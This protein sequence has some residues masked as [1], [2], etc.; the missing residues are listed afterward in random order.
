M[1]PKRKPSA[2][3]ASTTKRQKKVMTL[4]NTLELLNRLS[5]GESAAS[6]GRQYNINES[7]VC[8]IWK[9]EKAIRES[10]AAS[11]VSSTKVVTY[12]RDV[13]IERMEKAFSIWIEDNTSESMALSGPLIRAKAKCIYNHLSGTGCTSTSDAPS[14]YGTSSTSSFTASR[15]WFHHFKEWHCLKSVKLS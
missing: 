8:Y 4:S 6:V 3:D 1:A 7:S 11:A 14:D 12:V 10:V 15:G 9:N 5:K 13:Y 2:G